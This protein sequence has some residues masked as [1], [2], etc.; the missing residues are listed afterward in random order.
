TS[1][2][3]ENP[4]T[5]IGGHASGAGFIKLEEEFTV[6][7]PELQDILAPRHPDGVGVVRIFLT[8]VGIP[9]WSP[10]AARAITAIG[11]T[12]T[13]KGSEREDRSHTGRTQNGL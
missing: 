8:L 13:G 9:G 1:P 2:G 7:G 12:A 10:R 6:V 11:N 3:P 5:W 4:P